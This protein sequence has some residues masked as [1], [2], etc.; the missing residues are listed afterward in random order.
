MKF[1]TVSAQFNSRMI[2]RAHTVCYLS[3]TGDA[4]THKRLTDSL[5]PEEKKNLVWNGRLTGF[6]VRAH[7][8]LGSRTPNCCSRLKTKR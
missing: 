4:D 6:F 7:Q 8:R 3:A 1:H 5:E 2:I